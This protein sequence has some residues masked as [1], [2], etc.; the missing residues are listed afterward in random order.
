MAGKSICEIKS[1]KEGLKP[2]LVAEEVEAET[3]SVDFGWVGILLVDAFVAG[4]LVKR[5]DG[6]IS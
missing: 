2:L 5:A 3:K 6:G 4:V 1:S